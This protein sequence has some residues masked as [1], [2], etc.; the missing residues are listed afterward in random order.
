MGKF[1]NAEKV[2]LRDKETQ[3]LIAVYPLQAEGTDD[4][5]SETVRDWFY[6]QSCAAED[7]LLTAYVDVLTE[8]EFKHDLEAD[9]MAFQL[10][11]SGIDGFIKAREQLSTL[12]RQ[13]FGLDAEIKA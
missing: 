8:A 1:A 5:I 12:L 6:K 11:Q 13:S 10:L 3:K 2:G 9:L 4:E 7:R